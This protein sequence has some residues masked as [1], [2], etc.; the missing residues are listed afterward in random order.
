M[1]SVAIYADLSCGG[2]IW[3]ENLLS[4]ISN[5]PLDTAE[6]IGSKYMKT[7]FADQVNSL[8]REI[9]QFPAP[10]LGVQVTCW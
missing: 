10:H 1:H 3:K 2:H 8:N 7:N 9:Y 4:Q 6:D 5:D